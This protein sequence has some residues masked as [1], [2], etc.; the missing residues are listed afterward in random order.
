M[1]DLNQA[2]RNQELLEPKFMMSMYASGAFPMTEENGDINWYLPDTRAIIK[3]NEFS[4]PKSLK[5]FME[6]SDFEFKYDKDVIKTVKECAKRDKTWI[7]NELIKAYKKLMEFG[8]LHSV[9]VYQKSKLVGGLFGV[10]Y[11]GAFF[12]ESMFSNVSQASKS[13][14]VKLFERLKEKDFLFVDV[15]FRTK[16]LAMFGAKEISFQEYVK[17]LIKAYLNDVRF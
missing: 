10:T 13:A 17:L 8:Y 15:Q 4:I 16:H 11:K 1:N 9:E 12:G 6:T 3:I 7:S 2:I 5:K 14:M